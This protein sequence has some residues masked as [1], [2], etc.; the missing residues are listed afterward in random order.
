[1]K[2]TRKISDAIFRAITATGFITGARWKVFLYIWNNGPCTQ[3]Q[4]KRDLMEA[5]DKTT[6]TITTRFSELESMGVI[7]IVGKVLDPV[8]ANYYI[9]LWDISGRLPVKFVDPKIRYTDFVVRTADR[10]HTFKT[11]EKAMQFYKSTAGA[12]SL[13]RRKCVEEVLIQTDAASTL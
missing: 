1:M 8:R 3:T 2:H 7:E 5:R 9:S 12:Q 6:S 10:T 11:S 4:A 13:T